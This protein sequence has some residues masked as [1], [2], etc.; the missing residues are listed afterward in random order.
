[1]CLW[2]TAAGLSL[3]AEVL[4]AGAEKLWQSWSRPFLKEIEEGDAGRD[5]KRTA[6]HCRSKNTVH[7]FSANLARHQSHR[8]EVEWEVN[9]ATEENICNDW[10]RGLCVNLNAFMETSCSKTCHYG[11]VYYYVICTGAFWLLVQEY[12]L[13][14]SQLCSSIL[15]KN[16]LLT[17]VLILIL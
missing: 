5:R 12:E 15:L 13:L 16:T 11:L 1:M 10:R 9:S 7:S 2:S 14:W 6:A 17:Y 3:G 4:G 8:L